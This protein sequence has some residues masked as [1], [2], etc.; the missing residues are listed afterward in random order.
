MKTKHISFIVVLVLL[1]STVLSLNLSGLDYVSFRATEEDGLAVLHWRDYQSEEQDLPT[2][3][4]LRKDGLEGQWKM[5]G[6]TKQS[7]WKD[8]ALPEILLEAEHP[9]RYRLKFRE[10]GEE[11]QVECRLERNRGGLRKAFAS[12]KAMFR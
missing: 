8:Q 2:Y 9:V 1:A 11:K 4:V 7:N 3:T 12:I 6:Q 10:N 5:I